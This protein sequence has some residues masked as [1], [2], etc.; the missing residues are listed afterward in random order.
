MPHAHTPDRTQTLP[1]LLD[2]RRARKQGLNAIWQRQRTR[3]A[4]IITYAR[5]NSPYYRKFYQDLPEQIENPTLL[6]VTS[7]KI[8]MPHFDEWATDREVSIEQVSAFVDNPDLIGE[9]FLPP[10]SSAT[11]ARS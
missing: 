2:A 9:R 11:R 8:L 6:P 1:L 4:E 3:L 5:A 7:K 10:S